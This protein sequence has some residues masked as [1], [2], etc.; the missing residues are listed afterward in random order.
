M[1][2]SHWYSFVLQV[3]EQVVTDCSRECSP[4]CCSYLVLV[5]KFTDACEP[6][7]CGN[8]DENIEGS[9]SEEDTVDD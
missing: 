2:F 5:M 7:N 9:N 1:H 4:S 3:L 6:L 8:T